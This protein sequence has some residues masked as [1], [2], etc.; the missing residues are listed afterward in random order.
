MEKGHKLILIATSS[1]SLVVFIF[2]GLICVCRRKG[3]RNDES[4]DTESSFESSKEMEIN[5]N[6]IRFNGDEDLTCADILDAPGEVIGKSKYGTLYKANLATNNSIVCLRFLRPTCTEKVQ[7]L[8][9]MLQLMGSI[10]HPNLVPL[11]GFYSGRRGEKLLV[12]PFYEMGNLAQFIKDGK[13]ECHKWTVICRISMGIARGLDYLHTGFQKPIIHGNLK[14]KN[15]LLGQNH[16]PFVSDFGLHTFLKQDAAQEMLDEADIEGYKAPELMKMEETNEA[17]DIYNFGVILLELLTGKEA[18]NKKGNPNQDSYLATTLRIAIL[19]NRISDLYHTDILVDEDNGDGSLMNEERVLG[20]FRMAMDC[21]SPSPSLRP[22]IKQISVPQDSLREILVSINRKSEEI[23]LMPSVV[24]P[25]WQE[26]ASGF[27]SSSGIKLKEAGQSAGTFVG[28]VAKDAKG[29]V[30]EAAGKFGS[31]V[32]NRWSLFQQPST[33]Q[34]MQEKLV[35]AAATTSFFLRKGV[36]E[37]KEKVVVGKIKVEEVAKKT[38]QKSK[39]L[40]TDIERWQ[41]GVASTDVFGVPIEVTVQRQESSKPVPF[42]LIKCADYLVLSGLNSPDLFKSEGN[43]KAIQ[44]LVSLYNQDLNA[45]LPENVN[46][47]DVAALVKCYLASLPQPLITPDLHNEVRGAR[48]S[49]PLMRSILKKLPTVNYMTLELI[50]ALLLR[51]SKKS[52]LNKMDAGSLAMEMAPIIMWQ[53][54]QPPETYKQFWNQPSKT[55]SNANLDSVQNYNEWDMLADE[56]E[57]S[58]VSSAIPLDDGVR[59]D[60]SGIEVLQCLIE[61]HNAI[62]TDANETVW[63]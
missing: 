11:C 14:S 46:P 30:S 45:P 2:L 44:Q 9:P 54:G 18:V 47:I 62:F 38:A 7:D 17:T 42:L 39:T 36:S 13:D 4:R 20:L 29:N 59:I 60:F 51:V 43:K 1:I 57:D 58:D 37:T 25:Q 10:Q 27:F 23:S 41:K 33:R 34:A 26:K 53:K 24:S 52:L 35:N 55:Q 3:S 21:C 19:D 12:H 32:K 5:G 40:L 49:I 61:H 16:Q 15:I 31:V 56:S 48:S 28:E 6:L 63:R 50:T 8:M 22:D